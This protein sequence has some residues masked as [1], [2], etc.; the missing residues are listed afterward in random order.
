MATTARTNTNRSTLQVAAAVVGAVFLAV[1]VLGFVP[2]VTADF[3]RLGVFGDVGARLL[4]LFGVNWLENLVHLGYGVAGLALASTASRARLYFVVGG[5]LYLVVALY[6][7]AT[8][9]HHDA[10]ILGVNQAGN[11][12]HL[13]LGVGM[14]ALGVA[15]GKDVRTTRS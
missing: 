4:G 13:G 3:D 7:F 6:G 12:L 5:A 11:F 1:G 15:R 10:N 9:T 2:G 14:V 8:G